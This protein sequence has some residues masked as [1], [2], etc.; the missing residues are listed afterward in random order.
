MDEL[1]YLLTGLVSPDAEVEDRP[2]PCDS[3]ISGK[4]WQQICELATLEHF[5]NLPEDIEK[6]S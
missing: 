2:N 6:N 5:E 1:H 3:F 4:T